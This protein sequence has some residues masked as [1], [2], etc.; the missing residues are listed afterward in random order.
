MTICKL[1]VALPLRQV[2]SHL[3]SLCDESK[4]FAIAVVQD[5]ER[6]DDPDTYI[7][8]AIIDTRKGKGGRVD[9]GPFTYYPLSSTITV[10][11]K[12]AEKYEHEGRLAELFLWGHPEAGGGV[13]GTVRLLAMGNDV[14]VRFSPK[15]AL[16]REEIADEGAAHLR[17]FK[18]ITINHFN[19]LGLLV[20]KKIEPSRF[21]N[22]DTTSPAAESSTGG[23]DN[24]ESADDVK[25][26]IDAMRRHHRGSFNPITAREV[27]EAVPKAA[28]KWIHDGGRWGPAHFG[29]FCRVTPTTIGRYLKSLRAVRPEIGG[30]TLPGPGVKNP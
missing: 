29:P 30:F 14:I 11:Q 22:P 28:D 5:P 10:P 20:S 7:R 26:F 13:I 18:D 19:S 4:E 24:D 25:H 16:W 1:L 12:V 6:E 23:Q 17:K 3:I 2:Y 27:I 9:E 15:D 8:C 21:E